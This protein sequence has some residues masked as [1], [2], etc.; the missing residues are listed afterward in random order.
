MEKRKKRTVP[1]DSK[2]TKTDPVFRYQT[3]PVTVFL[4]IFKNSF[5]IQK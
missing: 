5:R 4:T 1:R 2:T 3:G